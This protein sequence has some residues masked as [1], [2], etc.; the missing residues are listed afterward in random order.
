MLFC[1]WWFR[2]SAYGMG[3]KVLSDM[4]GASLVLFETGFWDLVMCIWAICAILAILAISM[5]RSKNIGKGKGPS[6][7]MEWAVKKRKSDSSQLVKKGK[8]KQIESSESEEMSDSDD[9]D[10]IEAMFAED[11]ESD[12]EKWTRS[13]ANRG[14]HCE[15]GVKL[16]TFLYSHPI[17]GIIQEQNMHFV[18][19]EVRGYLPS[20]V[21]E[22]YTNLKENQRTETVLETSVMGKQLRFTPDSIAHALQYIRPDA[23]DRPYP[24]RAITDFDAQL[25]TEAMCTHPVPMSG[26]MKKEFVPGKLKPEYA[27]MNK[28]IH[29]R[30]GPKGNEKSPS[31]EQI[32]FLYEVMTGKLIDY[33]LVIW[34]VMRDFLQFSHESQLIPFPSL[35]TSI[36]E[37]AGMRGSV[38]EKKVLPRLGS[39]TNKTEAKSRVASTKPQPSQ[40]SVPPPGITSSI[41]P[42]PLSTSPLNRMERRIKGWFKCILGKQ[43]QLDRRLSRLES[44]IFQGEPAMADAT[45]PDLEG[46]SEELD[47]CVDEDA[48]S[49]AED[50]DDA[51]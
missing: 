50:E 51:A 46:D 7:S 20:V 31:R 43:K 13:I 48:F 22:F 24:L 25:F 8:G 11:S 28:I 29:D 37:E 45:S 19:T 35:V 36:V 27:L 39:I 1:T 3:R 10:E 47:D 2:V 12:Q 30:I 21:R 38:K 4:H 15:R 42:T 9:D 5:A 41:A 6:S 33:A 49:S 23:S 17:R 32:Q 14:F 26:F 16:E 40:P 44:H 18:H 34:C